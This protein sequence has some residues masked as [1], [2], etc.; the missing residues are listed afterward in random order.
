[1]SPR[2]KE[3]RKEGLKRRRREKEKGGRE[4]KKEKRASIAD[5]PGG[6]GDDLELGNEED[7]EWCSQDQSYPYIISSLYWR[8]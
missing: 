5:L 7:A 1:V 3:G 4:G 8:T 2:R 6:R